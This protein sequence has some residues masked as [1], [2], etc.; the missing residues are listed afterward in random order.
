MSLFPI[1]KS[2]RL[3]SFPKLVL[4]ANGSSCGDECRERAVAYGPLIVPK[5]KILGSRP[6]CFNR[7]NAIAILMLYRIEENKDKVFTFHSTI[8]S[9]AA[10]GYDFTFKCLP[11]MI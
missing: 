4:D 8:K 9:T 6:K 5:K 3:L 11:P 1:A 10:N 2:I 7:Q